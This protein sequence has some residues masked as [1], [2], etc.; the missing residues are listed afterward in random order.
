MILHS[1]VLTIVA[2]AQKLLISHT[3]C[4]LKLA[5][6]VIPA[7]LCTNF[8]SLHRLF[9]ADSMIYIYTA[10]AAKCN[11]WQNATYG[12]MTSSWRAKS[13]LRSLKVTETG[14]NRKPASNFPLVTNSN[15]QPH[16]PPFTRQCDKNPVPVSFN[17]SLRVIPTNCRTKCGLKIKLKHWATRCWKLH[18]PMF[19]LLN[20]APKCDRQHQLQ[21][22]RRI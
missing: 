18:A 9:A 10:G 2:K 5:H 8:I 1:P 17:P 6:G 16:L 21:L 11:L 14:A 13:Y 7:N 12:K 4:Y 15:L 19:P 22:T 20:I 3:S